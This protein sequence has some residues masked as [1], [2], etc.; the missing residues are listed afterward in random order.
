MTAPRRGRPGA[1]LLRPDRRTGPDRRLHDRRIRAGPG[2]LEAALACDDRVNDPFPP[3]IGALNSYLH[4]Y[5]MYRA[6]A[7]RVTEIGRL[8]V[9]RT[10]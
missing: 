1:G 2:G 3:I 5:H 10:P 7:L 4:A 8:A 6:E 9:T